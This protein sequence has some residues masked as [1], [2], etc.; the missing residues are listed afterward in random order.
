MKLLVVT[1]EPVDATGVLVA[2]DGRL[3]LAIRARKQQSGF[4]TGR[5][6][7]HPPF[8]TAVVGQR[9]R[10]FR[11][12]EAEN[13]DEEPDRGIVVMDNERDEMK[14]GHDAILSRPFDIIYR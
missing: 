5:P 2:D 9:R 13:I 4:G 12:L 14:M 6:D 1:P 10:I 7:H 3:L 11:E 8:R